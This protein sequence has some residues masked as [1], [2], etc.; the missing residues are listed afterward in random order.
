MIC[1]F[2]CAGPDDRGLDCGSNSNAVPRTGIL[3]S[4][5]KYRRITPDSA[6]VL[7][8]G[9]DPVRLLSREEGIVTR[10]CGYEDPGERSATPVVSAATAPMMEVSA[11]QNRR[12]ADAAFVHSATGRLF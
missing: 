3:V 11:L 12:R 4:G 1:A 7:V 10:V 6:I 8:I 5:E 2:G 9:M